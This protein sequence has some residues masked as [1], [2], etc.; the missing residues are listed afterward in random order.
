[1]HAS[2]TTRP[3][4]RTVVTVMSLITLTI[5]AACSKSE[6]STRDT[7]SSGVSGAVRAA[8]VRID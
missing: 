3:R 6:N 2:H 4:A 5:S 1:M 8:G 7:T